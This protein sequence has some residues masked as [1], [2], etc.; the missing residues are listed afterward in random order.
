MLWPITVT[1]K[2]KFDSKKNQQKLRKPSLW[3]FNVKFLETE[4][5]MKL[6]EI[7]SKIKLP[8]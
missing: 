8:C 1:E 4:S 6:N 7:A 3:K 2:G 5:G